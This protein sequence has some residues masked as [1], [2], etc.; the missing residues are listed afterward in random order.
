MTSPSP[1]DFPS[2]Y[3]PALLGLITYLPATPLA[4]A[5]A[6]V[7]KAP[8]CNYLCPLAMQCNYLSSSN[9]MQHL[10]PLA[11]LYRPALCN[12]LRLS[13]NTFSL[14]NFFASLQ[15]IFAILWM[16]TSLK[17]HIC[18]SPL[19]MF[20][21]EEQSFTPPLL[22]PYSL[23]LAKKI[24]CR[25]K[26]HRPKAVFNRIYHWCHNHLNAAT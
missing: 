9:A 1:C 23:A 8:S 4:L 20:A 26:N 10:C 12:Y 2:L 14:C 18:H 17:N 25:L 7:L 15:I 11:M 5:T 6:V 13:V 24:V 21:N 16:M 22:T 19:L 3:C